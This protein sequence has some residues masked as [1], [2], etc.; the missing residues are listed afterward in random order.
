MISFTKRR[1]TFPTVFFRVPAE[2]FQDC[3]GDIYGVFQEQVQ[4]RVKCLSVS[5]WLFGFLFKP[6]RIPCWLIFL[7]FNHQLFGQNAY[8]MVFQYPGWTRSSL[9]FLLRGA[10]HCKINSEIVGSWP[11]FFVFLQRVPA[12][13]VDQLKGK[14]DS[15]RPTLNGG[16]CVPDSP[17]TFYSQLTF[18]LS[19]FNE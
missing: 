11:V 1:R 15:P 3:L 10:Q 18:Y 4:I 8:S 6:G 14:Y 12:F 16:F 13:L 9:G 2:S 17:W 5:W 7:S 19:K